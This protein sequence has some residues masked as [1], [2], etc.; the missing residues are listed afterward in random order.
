MSVEANYRHVTVLDNRDS[1]FEDFAKHQF[2]KWVFSFIPEWQ[3]GFVSEHGT[4]DYGAALAFTMQDCLE[5]RQE[6]LLI[7]TD[8]AGAFDRC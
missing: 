3:F 4:V 6:G 2:E 8:I 1:V 7:A 5:R